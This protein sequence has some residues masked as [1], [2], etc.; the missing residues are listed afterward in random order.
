ML[1]YPRFTHL[2]LTGPFEVFGR[3]PGARVVA[4]AASREPVVSDTGLRLV[5]ELTLA[6]S[7]ALD[8]ISVPGGPGVNEQLEHDEML[9]FLAR[10]G[11]S[12]RYVTSVCSGALILGAAGLLNGY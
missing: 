11:A 12:A 8:V 6:E 2:D 9:E 10:Q 4:L 1:L 3:I 7:P 5:P